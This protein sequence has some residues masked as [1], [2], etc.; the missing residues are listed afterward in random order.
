MM[1]NRPRGIIKPPSMKIDNKAKFDKLL[2]TG[3]VLQ[4]A[5]SNRNREADI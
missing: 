2:D 3:F 4:I 1:N 5:A